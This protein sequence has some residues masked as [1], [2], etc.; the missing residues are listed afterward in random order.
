MKTKIWGLV[1]IAVLIPT[2]GFYPCMAGEG[3]DDSAA[4]SLVDT[5]QSSGDAAGMVSE[6]NDEGA[7]AQAGS[8]FDGNEAADPPPLVDL[9][10][11]DPHCTVD[12]NDLKKDDPPAPSLKPS[13][14]PPLPPSE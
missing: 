13:Y 14:V 4:G 6:G 7:R 1:A 12:P 3:D 8:G 11:C 2:L 5:A 10:H 9:R